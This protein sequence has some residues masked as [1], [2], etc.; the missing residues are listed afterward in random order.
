MT[1]DRELANAISDGINCIAELASKLREVECEN[2]EKPNLA[3]PEWSKDLEAMERAFEAVM[4]NEVI[5]SLS[6]TNEDVVRLRR[7]RV[8]VSEWLSHG[9]ASKEL[10][11]LADATLSSFGLLTDSARKDAD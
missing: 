9:H 7:V 11:G 5:T 4:R 6:I 10:R 1:A 8:L 2:S 3:S